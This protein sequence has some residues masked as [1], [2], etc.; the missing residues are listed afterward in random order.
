MRALA[1]LLLIVITGAAM[2]LPAA[3]GGDSAPVNS[4]PEAGTDTLPPFAEFGYDTRPSNTKCVAPARPPVASSVQLQKTFA[5][6]TLDTPMAIAQIP[7]DSTRFFVAERSG[8]MVSFSS[9]NPVDATKTTVLTLPPVNTSGEGGFLGFA[10]HPKFATNGHLYVSYTTDSA[11]AM[12]GMQS[13]VARFT[14]ADGG[15]TFGNYLK[16][17]SFDQPFTNHKGGDVH[18]GNDGY[19]YLSFGDGGS[20]GDPLGHGQNKNL[21]FAKILRIDI[22]NVPI[23]KTYGIPPTNPFATGGGE[24]STYAYGLRNAFR[25]SIDRATNQINVGDVGQNLW[26]E[27]DLDLK[28]GG[29]YGWNIME[30]THCYKPATN[31]PTAGLIQPDYDYDHMMGQAIIGGLVYRG[32]SIPSYV[33]T[34]VFGDFVNGRVWSLVIGSDGK[35]I[36]TDV[37]NGGGGAWVQFGED[38]DG[39]VYAVSL[40]GGVFKLV[41]QGV[42]PP[43][44]FP[45]TLSKTGCVDPTDAKKPASGIIPYGP[46]SPLWSDGAE[47]ERY[48]ALPDGKT[49]TVNAEGH[50]DYPIGTVMMKVF[51]VGG[52]R[53]ETRLMVR[54]DDGGWAG[55]TYEWNDEETDASLL[56]SSKSKQVGNQT[57]YYPTRS[58]CMRC[59]TDAAGKTLGPELGQLNFEFPY[60]TTN[61]TAN[62]LKTLDHI[63][64]FS[65]PLGDVTQLAAYPNPLG[66]APIES[67]AKAYLHANCSMCHRPNGGGGGTMDFRYSTPLSAMQTCNAKPAA[68]DLGIANSKVLVPGDSAHSLIV[69]RPSRLDANRMPPLATNVVDT[70]AVGVLD[71]WV[72][73]LTSCP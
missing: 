73:S 49:I 63:N 34:Y 18:F 23:G 9:S 12:S 8:T 33:G 39:E 52:K 20:G 4:A 14:S 26:E 70:A 51:K 54:H 40:Q 62:Q 41:A 21:F 36:V 43:S 44:T 68:G 17:F 55:Y 69:Q 11:T 48:M 1:F 29:N 66:T 47:K 30:G 58:E 38:N 3:C 13:V 31:C 46:I 60:A 15:K 10:F 45:D 64:M 32:K 59:H 50:F 28:L 19:L 42:Q 35:A 37:P 2:T 67:R 25:F 72:K 27:V 71:Q 65:A 56:V 5:G 22:D 16:L 24:P 57:W 61:R 53:V 6:L 7:G